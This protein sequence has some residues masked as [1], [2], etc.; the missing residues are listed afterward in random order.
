MIE[1]IAILIPFAGIGVGVFAIWTSHQQKMM[2]MQSKISAEKAAQYAASNQQLEQRVR[3]LERIVTDK[4]F[5]VAGQIESLR[6]EPE[7]KELN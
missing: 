5:D 1:N 7:V 2:K 3:V 6:D 4:G